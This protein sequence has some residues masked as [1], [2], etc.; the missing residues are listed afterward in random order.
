MAGEYPH[1]EK[2]VR[3]YAQQVEQEIEKRLHGYG[4]IAS[5]KLY[6]SIRYVMEVSSSRIKLS[7]LMAP[8]GVYVDK[9]RKPGKMP[10]LKAIQRWCRI[11]GIEEA[12]AFPIARKIGKEGIAPTN[13]FTIP[14]TRRAKQFAENVRKSLVLDT[15]QAIKKNIVESAKNEKGTTALIKIR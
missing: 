4:K 9:G 3:T 14:T 2:Y 5:G 12:A 13:F 7:F 15:E 10:P 8:Y 11:K 1:T 6:D